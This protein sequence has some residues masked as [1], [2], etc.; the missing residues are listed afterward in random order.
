MSRTSESNGL[1]LGNTSLS[2]DKFEQVK[3]V[4]CPESMIKT[5][6]GQ[7]KSCVSYIYII[8]ILPFSGCVITGQLGE[9]SK[10]QFRYLK[11]G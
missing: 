9:T 10:P 8:L 3:I 7:L 2:S 11:N 1:T 5:T 6:K 4:V